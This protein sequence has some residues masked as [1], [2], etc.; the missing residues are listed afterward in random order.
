MVKQGCDGEPQTP[1]MWP[2]RGQGLWA[3]SSPAEVLE[4]IEG[5]LWEGPAQEAVRCARNSPL[6][7]VL[8]AQHSL[9]FK[10]SPCRFVEGRATSG[11]YGSTVSAVGMSCGG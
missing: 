1:P 6:Q 7:D 2:E 5:N 11:C 4:D 10:R 3:P 8:G 9:G